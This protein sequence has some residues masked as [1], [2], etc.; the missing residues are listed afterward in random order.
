MH[1]LQ[2]ELT[3]LRALNPKA[4]A[5][6]ASS[7]TS[8]VPPTSISRRSSQSSVGAAIEALLSAAED[9]AAAS[10]GN[11]FAGPAIGGDEVVPEGW[12]EVSEPASGIVYNH[13]VKPG[14]ISWER[15]TAVRAATGGVN[16]GEPSMESV[17]LFP[18]SSKSAPPEVSE[19]T[20]TQPTD[21]A[22]KV[23]DPTTGKTYV[24]NHRTSV[25]AWTR[26]QAAT[27]SLTSSEALSR[28][29][30]ISTS[31]ADPPNQSD[32]A[33]PKTSSASDDS[34]DAE[35]EDDADVPVPE[36]KLEARGYCALE[37]A[38]ESA[39]DATSSSTTIEPL[40]AVE[41]PGRKSN[42]EAASSDDLA[43]AN[44]VA[45]SSEKDEG[46]SVPFIPPVTVGF[47]LTSYT[48][49]AVPRGEVSIAVIP[50]GVG[51]EDVRAAHEAF[52]LFY[53]VPFQTISHA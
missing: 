29:A 11:E 27:H 36:A 42:E 12:E 45:A 33:E 51:A 52:Y 46:S 20:E 6:A 37:I 43:V 5:L 53:V 7:P 31:A 4:A 38:L 16:D 48:P 28:E 47:L 24:H 49:Y 19:Q 14:G 50:K 32:A 26:E 1:K 3:I 23:V 35:K 30:E 34:G 17:S 40:P 2:E 21:D 13:N 8:S 39:A 18:S 41:P 44:G 9:G 15:P 10:S 22:E 25:T